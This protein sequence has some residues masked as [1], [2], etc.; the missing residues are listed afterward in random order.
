VD[1]SALLI[2]GPAGGLGASER[3]VRT[4]MPLSAGGRHSADALVVAGGWRDEAALREAL[5]GLG[6]K[7]TAL[8]LRIDRRKAGM[9]MA[10]VKPS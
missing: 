2:R 10:R 7:L 3:V 1:A 8:G 6:G 9:R 4:L 5:A